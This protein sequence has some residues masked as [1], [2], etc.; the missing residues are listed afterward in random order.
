MKAIDSTKRTVELV[1]VFFEIE[2]E[3]TALVSLMN[4]LDVEARATYEAD[5]DA[6]EKKMECQIVSLE[7]HLKSSDA[8]ADALDAYADGGKL[9]LIEMLEAAA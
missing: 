6:V 9:G 4:D 5:R 1:T 2:E 8:V 3:K 7:G